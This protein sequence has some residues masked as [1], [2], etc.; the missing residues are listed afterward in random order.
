MAGIKSAYTLLEA[1]EFLR[2][3]A[4]VSELSTNDL[5]VLASEGRLSVCFSYRGKLGLFRNYNECQEPPTHDELAKSVWGAAVRTVYF[6]GILRSMNKPVPNTPIEDLKGKVQK[7]HALCPVEVVPV[8][9]FSAVLPVELGEPEGHHWRRVYE[10][11]NPFAG[12][13]LTSSVPEAEWL[14]QAE[15]IRRLVAESDT[16]NEPAHQSAAGGGPDPKVQGFGVEPGR[17][18]VSTRQKRRHTLTL[19]IESAQSKCSNPEDVA[20]VWV[21]L[22][23]MAEQREGLLLGATEEG[24]QWLK[25]GD[26]SILSR[27]SLAGIIK[28]QK[29]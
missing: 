23:V 19:I 10:G 7:A 2:R 16:D 3:K 29:A 14:F 15:D 24:I 5:V 8:T 9:A 28:R 22:C 11:R 18:I 25:N 26:V 21:Q 12:T 13:A 4:G 17:R 27:R 6:N 20:A 1:T